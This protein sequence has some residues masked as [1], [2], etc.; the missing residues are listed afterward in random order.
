MLPVDP[1]ARR[2]ASEVKKRLSEDAGGGSDH[3]ALVRGRLSAMGSI[4][5]PCSMLDCC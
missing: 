4:A 1:G 5:P 3:L 2:A